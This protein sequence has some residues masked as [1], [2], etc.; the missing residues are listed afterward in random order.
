MYV[1]VLSSLPYTQST[2]NARRHSRQLRRRRRPASTLVSSPPGLAVT[3]V[4]TGPARRPAAAPPPAVLAVCVPLLRGRHRTRRRCSNQGR[5]WTQEL[6]REAG[7]L[8]CHSTLV[9]MQGGTMARCDAAKGGP[10]RGDFPRK[11]CALPAGGCSSCS[12]WHRSSGQDFPDALYFEQCCTMTMGR[13]GVR[14]NHVRRAS[15]TSLTSLSRGSVD[16]MW[17][18]QLRGKLLCSVAPP[19]RPAA[20]SQGGEV[21]GNSTR[22]LSYEA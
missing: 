2:T 22:S 21:R 9:A 7:A 13:G 3:F 6:T 19:E 5:D 18:G 17:C 1:T 12:S 10:R 11:R 15:S 20:W 14:A 8:R 4:A 16:V